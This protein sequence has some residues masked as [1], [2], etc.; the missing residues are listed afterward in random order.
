[1]SAVAFGESGDVAGGAVCTSKGRKQGKLDAFA[2]FRH[3]PSVDAV[4]FCVY[5]IRVQEGNIM[6]KRDITEL[7]REIYQR[8]KPLGLEK[9]VLFGSIARGEDDSDSDIDLYVVTNDE[10]VPATWSDKNR[11]YLSVARQLR[12]LRR[13]YP[14]DLIVHTK[15][16]Y[17]KFI[18]QQSFMAG[19]ILNTGIPIV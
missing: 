1:M 16:M 15:A 10:S 12:D 3:K 11:I 13:Q 8:L 6:S 2:L 18:Q 14:I 9:V 17:H 19:E 7:K 5:V 4:S